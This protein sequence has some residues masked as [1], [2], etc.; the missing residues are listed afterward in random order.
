MALIEQK[1]LI[2]N[3][4]KVSWIEYNTEFLDGFNDSIMIYRKVNEN[5]FTDDGYTVF[6]LDC[7]VPNWRETGTVEKICKRY[8][9]KI[10]SNYTELYA[11]HDSQLMQTIIA[12]Y[13]WI[14]FKNEIQ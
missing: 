13:A 11:S 6:N 10:G 5:Y 4:G 8:G 7:L 14:E 12:I 3:N 2:V 1:R 9:C